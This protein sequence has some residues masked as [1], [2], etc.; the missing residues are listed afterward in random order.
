MVEGWVERGAAGLAEM[1]RATREA[2]ARAPGADGRPAPE[3]W[4]LSFALGETA[5]SGRG[6][7]AFREGALQ[8][9]FEL[10]PLGAAQGH[11]GSGLSFGRALS[12]ESLTKQGVVLDG[13]AG[14]DVSKRAGKAI[15]SGLVGDAQVGALDGRARTAERR[16]RESA[17]RHGLAAS[18]AAV[19]GRGGRVEI[20]A[21]VEAIEAA[22][23]TPEGLD[24]LRAAK[25]LGA[26]ERSEALAA[27]AADPRA[28]VASAGEGAKGEAH[29][30]DKGDRGD[31]PDGVR[32][33]KAD[34]GRPARDASDAQLIRAEFPGVEDDGE[35]TDPQGEAGE[36]A[37]FASTPGNRLARW[38]EAQAIRASW[39]LG[40]PSTGTSG[41]EPMDQRAQD[42]PYFPSSDEMIRGDMRTG[43]QVP[44]RADKGASLTFDI[45]AVAE[46]PE[47]VA[48]GF[49][50][51]L[52]N[53][54]S[55]TVELGAKAVGGAALAGPSWVSVQMA[56]ALGLDAR[57]ERN[58]ELY[59][60]VADAVWGLDVPTL[61]YETDAEETGALLGIVGTSVVGAAGLVRGSAHGAGAVIDEVAVVPKTRVQTPGL[62]IGP[63][64]GNPHAAET[65]DNLLP[66]GG[67]RDLT[68]TD[69]PPIA[70]ATSQKQNRHI[71]GRPEYRGGGY[72]GS[73]D[74]AQRVLNEYH[75]GTTTIIGQTANG[76]PVVRSSTVRGINVNVGAGYPAQPTDTFIIKGTT[77]PSVVPTNPNW[78]P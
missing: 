7:A 71:V 74:D 17:L 26:K 61:D 35:A 22:L 11:A 54:I 8:R 32:G 70:T 77:R 51:S 41:L 58:R 10:D 37:P 66:M 16:D 30:A 60:D 3:A 55:E 13:V 64:P 19:H 57:A 20:A 62:G 72:L 44:A 12:G 31:E 45:G 18:I 56:D 38:E 24:Y 27:L 25:A 9:A 68:K 69:F 49:G 2:A 78:S 21:G 42:Y 6:E 47:E 52:A 73:A 36:D 67:P 50:K 46:D 15:V 63:P 43:G 33:A 4:A 34:K 76:F 39:G 28:A 23:A 65:A 59:D 48:T 53:A 1:D 75:N 5:A 14:G 29:K 40:T